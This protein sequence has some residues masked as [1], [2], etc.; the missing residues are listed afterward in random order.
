MRLE[1]TPETVDVNVHPTKLEVRFQDS[2]KLY[3]L[4][5]GAIR[6]R[7]LTSDLTARLGGPAAASEAAA[8][9]ADATPAGQGA[10]EAA[11]WAR[12]TPLPLETPSPTARTLEVLDTLRR[13][14]EEAGAD[15]LAEARSANALGGS[16][17]A[18]AP[19]G[20]ASSTAAPRDEPG[21]ACGAE[22]P[23]S[24]GPNEPPW[25]AVPAGGGVAEEAASQPGPM[26]AGSTALGMQV[27]NRYLVTESPEGLVV[28]DQHALHER[29]LYE[30]FRAKSL[31][32]QLETQPLLVPEPVTLP[33]QETAAVLQ[34]ADTLAQLG[35]GVEP[36]GGD[37]VL[38]TR[39]PAMLSRMPPREVLRNIVELLMAPG[40]RVERR[41]LL[42]EL[43]HMM[44]CKAAVKAGDRL[45]SGEVTALLEHRQL[46]Q[47]AHHCPH[48]RPT[49]LVFTP[50]ELDRRFKR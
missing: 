50:E 34:A 14:T 25:P 42:D 41:D 17:R 30:Q 21:R 2:G 45:T 24:D 40:R 19:P 20:E 33:P 49:A 32:G 4:L 29:I 37:T 13:R 6:N 12:Q 38:V 44:A 16:A 3:G 47:D 36:F 15:E 5:L 46:C 7:F 31:A 11:A 27:H 22:A 28:I 43:L 26:A 8:Q 10:P 1:L 48:G 35:I 18:A 9:P 39:C 23:L